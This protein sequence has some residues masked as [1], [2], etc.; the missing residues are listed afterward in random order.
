MLVTMNEVLQYANEK[1]IAIGSFNTPT[2]ENL[3]AVLEASEEKNVP[4][5]IMHAELHEPI[6]P[7][8]VIGPV[9][10]EL[11]KRSKTKVCVHLDHGEH[12]DYI[13]QALELG[14]TSVMYDGSSLDYETKVKNTKI[15]VEMAKK[16][17]ASVEAE[18]GILGG[19]ESLDNKKILKKEDMYTDPLL[20][21]R[22]VEDTKIDALACSFGTAHGIYKETPKLDFERLSLIHKLTGLP[23][24]MHGGS[25]VNKKDYVEAINRGVRKIN[26]YSYMGREGVIATRKYLQEFDN[27]TF[28]HEIAFNAKEAMKKDVLRAL[29]V[30]TDKIID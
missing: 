6:A 10:V 28:Y 19:R 24:V 26:Y 7:L 1:N 16:Y 12:L 27:I 30:F 3:M 22:F 18:I 23:I 4:V 17:N 8:S 13:K 29:K 20:A 5:I 25:G 14:F 21:K 2:L 15:C 11:A 9:M